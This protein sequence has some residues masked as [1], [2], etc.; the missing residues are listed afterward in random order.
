MGAEPVYLGPMEP[1]HP[2]REMPTR[3]CPAVYEAVCGDRPCARYESD[4]EA[5]WLAEV[6][7]PAALPGATGRNDLKAI[8]C[9]YIVPTKIVALGARAYVVTMYLGGNLPER[10]MVVVRSRGGRWVEKWESMRRLDDFRLATI[11]P[12]HPR[13]GDERVCVLPDPERLGEKLRRLTKARQ[14]IL[15]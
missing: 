12:G 2:C 3:H 13:Y 11:P 8:V 14:E 4:D 10:V 6:A 1:E 9:N 5:P 15:R 7:G